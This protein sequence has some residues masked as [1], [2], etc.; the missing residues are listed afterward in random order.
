MMDSWFE[1][2]NKEGDVQREN[3]PPAPPM[4]ARREPEISVSPSPASLQAQVDKLLLVNMALWSLLCEKTGLTNEE[5][6]QRIEKIDLADGKLDGKVQ[7]TAK[8]CPQC[9]RVIGVRHNR[10]IY[11]GCMPAT[12]SGFELFQPGPMVSSAPGGAA[13]G[14]G[15]VTGEEKA[16]R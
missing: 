16:Q 1:K 10:C 2:L 6:R 11:C 15:G 4:D 8:T 12:D 13:A 3:P 7:Q 14:Q 9:K 5:L